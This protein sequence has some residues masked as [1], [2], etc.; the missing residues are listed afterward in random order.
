[1]LFVFDTINLNPEKRQMFL[2]FLNK[3]LNH[4]LLLPF[5]GTIPHCN[6]SVTVS[7]SGI[8]DHFSLYQTTPET[9]ENLPYFQ[10][11]NDSILYNFGME[12][13]FVFTTMHQLTIQPCY[14]NPVLY[15]VIW[16]VRQY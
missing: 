4:I 6:S 5:K 7:F 2:I 14:C 15:L 10:N 16:L 8:L 12:F 3:F 1:M 9:I 11:L 13:V